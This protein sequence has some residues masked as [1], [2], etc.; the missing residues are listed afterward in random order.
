MASRTPPTFQLTAGQ[1]IVQ[2]QMKDADVMTDLHGLSP[3]AISNWDRQT[4]GTVGPINFVSDTSIGFLFASSP[5]PTVKFNPTDIASLSN[6]GLYFAIVHEFAHIHHGHPGNQHTDSKV[7]EYQADDTALV[8]AFMHD[9]LTAYKSADDFHTLILQQI[10]SCQQGGGSH[11]NNGDRKDRLEKLTNLI[12]DNAT[13]KV[14]VT[15]NLIDIAPMKSF[16]MEFMNILGLEE[17]DYKER[18]SNDQDMIDENDTGETKCEINTESTIK[19]SQFNQILSTDW[20]TNIANANIKYPG[21]NLS[22]TTEWV[23]TPL[24]V[25][26]HFKDTLPNG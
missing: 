26:R 21:L 7:N 19:V 20:R 6:E 25:Q 8:T 5:P 11:P 1:P 16:N 15:S 9:P 2:R 3:E 12:M 18:M 23:I 17:A 24:D 13:L 4:N 10:L 14:K 22:Y